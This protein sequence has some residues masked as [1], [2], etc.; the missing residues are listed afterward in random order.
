MVKVRY[1]T[2]ASDE[3]GGSY[4]YADYTPKQG[5]LIFEE[6]E[7]EKEIRIDIISHDSLVREDFFR[8]RLFDPQNGAKLHD[9]LQVI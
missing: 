5:I 1:E 8:I 6:G 9:K 4:P 3:D 2:Q 7:T